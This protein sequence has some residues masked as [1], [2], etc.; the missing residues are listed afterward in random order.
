MP[1]ITSVAEPPASAGG[2]SER[3][4]KPLTRNSCINELVNREIVA[5]DCCFENRGLPDSFVRT[6]PTSMHDGRFKNAFGQSFQ[7]AMTALQKKHLIYWAIGTGIFL[8]PFVMAV[9]NSLIRRKK[10][11]QSSSA[12]VRPD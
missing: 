1:P 3:R 9:L 11:G 10:D 6:D 5:I 12:E 2:S 8:L 7:N 4:K